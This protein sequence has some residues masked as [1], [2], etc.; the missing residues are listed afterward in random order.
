MAKV[1]GRLGAPPSVDT[2]EII[3]TRW[4]EVVGAE[5]ADHVHPVRVH[6]DV[7]VIRADHP[8]WVTRARMDSEH[9]VAAARGLGDTTV[10]RIEVVL[11]RPQ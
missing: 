3:F 6:G 1:L 2:M 4:A 5:L 11:Q 10:Q 8:A 7:L 9:I